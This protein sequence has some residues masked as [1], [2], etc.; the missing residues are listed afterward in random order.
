MAFAIKGLFYYNK[1]KATQRNYFLIIELSDRLYNMYL[2]ESNEQ[3]VWFESYLTYANSVLS[4]AMLCAYLI[5]KKVEYKFVAK[6]TFDFLLSKIYREQKIS[7]I[8]NVK[9]LMKGEVIDYEKS[10]AEQ[11]IDVAYTIMALEKFNEEFPNEGYLEIL[12]TSFNWFLG[13]NHLKQTMYNPCTAGCYDGLE[14]YNVNLNQG[15]ESTISYLLSRL[16]IERA[17]NTINKE[18]AHIEEL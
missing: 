14:K 9:W 17:K 4:E 5:T 6:I 10:G 2:H 8:Q 3:W 12:N 13:N 1:V 16:V 15:A 18:L 11:P 7:V